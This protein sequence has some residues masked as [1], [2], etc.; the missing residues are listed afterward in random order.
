MC[1]I[2][3]TPVFG[4]L[5]FTFCTVNYPDL[6]LKILTYNWRIDNWNSTKFGWYTGDISTSIFIHDNVFRF[7]SVIIFKVYMGVFPRS[8]SNLI[9]ARISVRSNDVILSAYSFYQTYEGWSKITWTFVLIFISF[10]IS[11]IIH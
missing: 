9:I 7:V 6:F 8:W 10:D 4:K 5:T 3:L 2:L 11:Q 1:H